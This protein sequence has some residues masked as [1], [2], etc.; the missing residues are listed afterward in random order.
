[1]SGQEYMLVHNIALF[2]IIILCDCLSAAL[3]PKKEV[4]LGT[5]KNKK[6]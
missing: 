1:M 4:F 2:D 6:Y 5:H 3:F